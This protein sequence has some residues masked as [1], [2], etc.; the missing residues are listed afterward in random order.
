MATFSMLF[1]ILLALG[2]IA[3]AGII[4][5]IAYVIHYLTTKNKHR[6]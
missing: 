6:S 2:F 5:A 1:W 3:V 4:F